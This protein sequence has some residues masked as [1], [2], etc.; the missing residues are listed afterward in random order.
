MMRGKVPEDD[1]LKVVR[2]L[3]SLREATPPFDVD[4][5]LA[6]ARR[7]RAIPVTHWWRPLVSL[8]QFAWGAGAAIAVLCIGALGLSAAFGPGWTSVPSAAAR[9]LLRA[10]EALCSAGLTM[11][12]AAMRLVPDLAARLPGANDYLNDTL[13]LALQ[14]A[15]VICGVMLVLT[16]LVVSHEAR[17]RRIAG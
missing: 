14:A 12:R 5:E 2:L 9:S 10:G 7:L 8:R 3:E 11:G 15:S 16:V 17:S 4:V 13:T 1:L 6:V